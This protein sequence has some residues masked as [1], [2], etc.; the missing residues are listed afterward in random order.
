[1]LKVG[2]NIG[3]QKINQNIVYDYVVFEWTYLKVLDIQITLVS[4]T[5]GQNLLPCKVWIFTLGP[6][7]IFINLYE[8]TFW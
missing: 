3:S 2:K 8:S 4:I 1:M 5:H 6:P 7:R